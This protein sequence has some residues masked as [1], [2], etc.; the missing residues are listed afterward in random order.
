MFIEVYLHQSL[1]NRKTIVEEKIERNRDHYPYI[2]I[3]LIYRNRR[4]DRINIQYIIYTRIRHTS[5]K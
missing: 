5:S 1:I 2:G 3:Y 4:I